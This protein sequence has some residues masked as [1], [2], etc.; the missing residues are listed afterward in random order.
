MISV[1]HR[2]SMLVGDA[3]GG[4]DNCGQ[5]S[6]PGDCVYK[7]V[8]QFGGLAGAMNLAR[9]L[10]IALVVFSVIGR[11]GEGHP[12][13]RHSHAWEIITGAF[14]VSMGITIAKHLMGLP[15]I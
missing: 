13:G 10:A 14:L 1:L 5:S 3:A 6:D 7:T 9:L 15:G 4:T 11:I 2:V 8:L 12:M